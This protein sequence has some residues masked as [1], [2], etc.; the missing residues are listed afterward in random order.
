MAQ[1]RGTVVGGRGEASRIGHKTS[2]LQTT[3]NGWSLGC[4]AAIEYNETLQRDEIVIKVTNG[5]GDGTENILLGK[6]A[7]IGGKVTRLQNNE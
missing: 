3:C 2:G 6:F 5:S 1:Y 7:N 4:T